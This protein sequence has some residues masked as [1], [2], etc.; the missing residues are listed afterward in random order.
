MP[1]KTFQVERMFLKFHNIYSPTLIGNPTQ[2]VG[3]YFEE[4]I[5]VIF[6]WFISKLRKTTVKPPMHVICPGVPRF[7]MDILYFYFRNIY[8]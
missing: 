2:I 8:G 3:S 4:V 1:V 6:L 5:F 7:T